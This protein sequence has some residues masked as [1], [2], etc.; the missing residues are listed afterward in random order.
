MLAKPREISTYLRYMKKLQ[1]HF[2]YNFLPNNKSR[3]VA[4]CNLTCIWNFPTINL[5]TVKQ[6]TKKLTRPKK[7]QLQLS[8]F[9]HFQFFKSKEP[10]VQNFRSLRSQLHFCITANWMKFCC[11]KKFVVI[12]ILFSKRFIYL[13]ELN[14]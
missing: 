1:I 9:C 4:S 10:T 2:R 7:R 3:N 14:S 8:T 12:H 11:Y 6:E 5:E 13:L